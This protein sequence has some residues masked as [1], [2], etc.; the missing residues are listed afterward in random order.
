MPVNK[1]IYG[2]E[3]LIDLSADTVTASDMVSGVTAHDASGEQIT[4]GID[5]ITSNTEIKIPGATPSFTSSTARIGLSY[6]MTIDRVFRK[7]STIVLQSKAENFGDA[8]AADVAKGRTFTSSAGLLV[9]GTMETDDTSAADPVIESLEIT[10]NGTYT[11]PDGVDGYSPIVVN[12]PSSGGGLPDTITPGDT[13]ILGSWVGAYI[14][15]TTVTDTGLSVTIPKDGT[16]RFYIAAYAASTYSFGSSS[17]PV[18]LYKNGEQAAETAAE[19]SPTAPL[20]L[21]LE[22]AAGDVI[23]VWAA[24]VTATYT[25]TGVRVLSLV[26]CI[27][28]EAL[29]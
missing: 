7:G 27:D 19:S 22:C 8:E 1:V 3:V 4:G 17:P 29:T 10:E 18:Y 28:M 2:S 24:G 6:A 9:E 26:A 21:E 16:Y 11:A 25:T 23:S 15:T 14:S 13:P 12:V 5:E 20:A